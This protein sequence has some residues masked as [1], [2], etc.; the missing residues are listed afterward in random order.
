MTK[1][2]M[3]IYAGTKY[4]ESKEIKN[5]LFMHSTLFLDISKQRADYINICM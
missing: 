2:L 1:Y 3:K 4:F 5:N